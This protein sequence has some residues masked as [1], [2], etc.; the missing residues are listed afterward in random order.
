MQA[1][2]VFALALSTNAPALPQAVAM[3]AAVTVGWALVLSLLG[4]L[5]CSRLPLAAR[6]LLAAGLALWTLLLGTW[7]PDYWLGLA[8][9]AP[10]LSAM[11]LCLVWLMRSLFP[12]KAGSVAAQKAFA[13]M[14][15]PCAPAETA[16]LGAAVL[17]GYVLLLDTFAVLPMQIY[18]WGFSPALLLG[19]LALGLVP[20]VLSGAR[21]EARNPALWV[22]PAALL[23]FAATHLPTGNVW[24]AVLDPWLWLVLQLTWLRRR[25]RRRSA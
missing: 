21:A 3:Q 18:A 10:S 23:V 8:F 13:G 12:S 25:Y 6:R 14:A 15:W 17:L 24:D 9:H 2:D 5:L 7:S 1:S 11:L 16:L 19:L 4:T 22:V 20:W